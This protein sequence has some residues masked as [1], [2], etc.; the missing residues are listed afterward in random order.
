MSGHGIS[1]RPKGSG[2]EMYAPA[3]DFAYNYPQMLKCIVDAFNKDYWPDLLEDMGD[4][5]KFD[6]LAGGDN[7]KD[8]VW[9]QTQKA[10]E[11]YCKFVSICTDD[12]EENVHD[13]LERS[14]FAEVDI[15]G[16]ITFL[17]MMGQVMTGQLFAGLRDVTPADASPKCLEF[18]QEGMNARK[19]LNGV[20]PARD[21]H[22]TQDILY[23]AVSNCFNQG[24]SKKEIREAVDQRLR[25]L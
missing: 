6:Y 21:K 17:A 20:D 16:Q 13:V 22:V 2:G 15:R 12:S 14:G 9:E 23:S 19:A 1:L 18:L 11:A 25:V 7:P 8:Y 5:E 4:D 3:R 24:M 10:E